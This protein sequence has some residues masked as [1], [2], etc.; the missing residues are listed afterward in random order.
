VLEI[1]MKFPLGDWTGLEARLAAWNAEAHPERIESDHYFNAADR[2][3]AT[4]DEAVRLRRV[5]TSNTLT[6]KGRKIDTETKA[7]REIEV[8]LADGDGPAGDAVAF[9]TALGMK[10]VAVISKRRRLFRFRRE[11]REVVACLDDAG[12]VGR[13]VELEI[14][15]EPSEFEEAK[16]LLLKLA[17]ELKL[18]EQERRSY[19]RMHLERAS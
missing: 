18:G 1:E 7:R 5:G 2:D 17:A 3:F 19:L 16:A 8:A 9:L 11:G 12:A 15:A 4:T 10:P 14:L 6:Y 13:F